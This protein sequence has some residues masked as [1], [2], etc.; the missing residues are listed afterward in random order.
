MKAITVYPGRD[1]DGKKEKYEKLTMRCGEMYTI[2]GNTGAGKSRLIKDIEQLA[3]G[4]SPTGRTVEL[5]GCR[6]DGEER[7]RASVELVAHLGQSMRF[8]LD[9]TVGEFLKLHGQCR[10]RDVSTEEVLALTNEMTAEPV[11]A[12]QNLNLL[13]GGQARSLMIAD[14]ALVCDSPIV[15]A[16]EIENA[17]IDKERALQALCSKDKLVLVVTHDPHTALM[18]PKRLVLENGGVTAVIER[19]PREEA[20]YR[21]LSEQYRNNRRLQEMLRRG[22][23]LAQ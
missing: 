4:D 14:V 5:D 1:K 10:G 18:A 19:S 15:L 22:Q 20:L 12:Q 9:I 6:L 8:V 7:Q 11:R 16:D 17:G 13:S 23:E 21:E 2:V 3:A